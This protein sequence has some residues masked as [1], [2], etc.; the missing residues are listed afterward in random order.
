MEKNLDTTKPRY[1]EHILPDLAVRKIEV[2][3]KLNCEVFIWENYFYLRVKCLRLY[4]PA[5]AF[6]L[7][8]S[9][10]WSWFGMLIKFFCQKQFSLITLHNRFQQHSLSKHA[11]FYKKSQHFDKKFAPDHEI[12][13]DLRLLSIVFPGHHLKPCL[14]CRKC[15]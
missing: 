10:N 2:P 1:S 7:F 15:T 8:V 11:T 12:N 13:S 6:V 9:K 3:K 5:H 4:L 14:S